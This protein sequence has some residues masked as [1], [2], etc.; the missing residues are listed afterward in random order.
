MGALKSAL[1]VSG[2]LRPCLQAE[3]VLL[4]VC[5][6]GSK[7]CVLIVLLLFAHR[8]KSLILLV[9][10]VVKTVEA[11]VTFANCGVQT[12]VVLKLC[13]L[14]SLMG[15][16]A[17]KLSLLFSPSVSHVGCHVRLCSRCSWEA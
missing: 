11:S 12:L 8:G 9:L 1:A 6:V 16:G 13:W 17:G 3:A 14:L 7:V 15:S 4:T 10:E 5:E 2:D